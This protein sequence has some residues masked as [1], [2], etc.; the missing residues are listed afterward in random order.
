M[1]YY[2][3]LD[4]EKMFISLF[5]PRRNRWIINV[6]IFHFLVQ[7]TDYA[8]FFNKNFCNLLEMTELPFL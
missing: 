4:K 2:L 3:L 6:R 1:L 8:V 5:S 7:K